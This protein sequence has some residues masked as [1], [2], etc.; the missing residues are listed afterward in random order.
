MVIADDV[1]HRIGKI[2]ALQNI[3]T[4]RRMN[5]HFREFSFS[6]LAGFV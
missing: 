3:A 5:F 1:F 2:D 6:E 4:H